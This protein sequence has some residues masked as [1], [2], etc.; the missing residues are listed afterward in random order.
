[1]AGS[2]MEEVFQ[3]AEK[4]FVSEDGIMDWLNSFERPARGA[5]EFTRDAVTVRDELI[6]SIATRGEAESID[7]TDLDNL[8]TLRTWL[9]E[10]KERIGQGEGTIRILKSQIKIAEQTE[11]EEVTRQ[12]E[13][14][15]EQIAKEQLL[16]EWKRAETV[17]EEKEARRLLKEELPYSLRSAKGWRSKEGLAAFRMV[18]G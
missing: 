9:D 11:I 10:E 13:I 14:R 16:S 6:S 7:L 5:T 4:Q 8:E 3:R 12:E 18:M 2:Y 15:T 17:E 1:M